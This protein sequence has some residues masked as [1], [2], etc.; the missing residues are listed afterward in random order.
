MINIVFVISGSHIWL[1]NIYL[2]WVFSMWMRLRLWPRYESNTSWLLCTVDVRYTH[3]MAISQICLQ[4]LSASL[5]KRNKQRLYR[6]GGDIEP[7]RNLYFNLSYKGLFMSGW[8]CCNTCRLMEEICLV[9]LPTMQITNDITAHNTFAPLWSLFRVMTAA[10][11]SSPTRAQGHWSLWRSWTS[12]SRLPRPAC[13]PCSISATWTRKPQLTRMTVNWTLCTKT[14][15]RK[16]TI[17][18]GLLLIEN[19][20]KCVLVPFS[21]E[22]KYNILFCEIVAFNELVNTL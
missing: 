1:L 17:F 13:Q 8:I 21:L 14:V 5:N 10:L 12:Q 7:C 15:S 3:L 6:Q 18:T 19:S 16:G 9:W 11:T 22:K 2:C 20:T 4:S